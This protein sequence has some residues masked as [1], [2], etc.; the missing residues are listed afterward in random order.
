[1]SKYQNTIDQCELAIKSVESILTPD[2]FQECMNYINQY[3]EWLLALEFAIDWLV[4]EDRKITQES[5]R[6]F[7]EA[8]K[9]MKLESDVRLKHLKLQIINANN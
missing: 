7:E 4:E 9:L 2:E 8:Y 1:M 3:N 5:Y 6:K